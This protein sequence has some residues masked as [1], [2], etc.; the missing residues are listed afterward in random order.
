MEIATTRVCTPIRVGVAVMALS[1]SATATA[2]PTGAIDGAVV[3]ANG[4]PL[5]GVVV[6]VT[7]PGGRGAEHVTG[8]D[9]RYTA[10]GLAVGDYVVTAVLSGFEFY[11]PGWQTRR[12]NT[13]VSIG[14]A[15]SA[16]G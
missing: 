2:Q 10:A 5:P 15:P 9:G 4:S 12:N 3:D 1:L 16:W 13:F 8:G 14:P 7:G 11:R 6:T